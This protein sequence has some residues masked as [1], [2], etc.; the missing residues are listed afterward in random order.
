ML[1]AS[2]GVAVGLFL[3]IM[4]GV[5]ATTG[6]SELNLPE[7]IELVYPRDG[8]SILRQDAISVDLMPGYTGELEIDGV[9]VPT[10]QADTNRNAAPGD[11]VPDVLTVKFDPG[12]NKLTYQPREGAP[13]ES[14]E[15]GTH[16][17]MVIYWRIDQ[18]PERAYSY[19]WTFKVS[20]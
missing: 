20:L 1:F 14:F 7:E 5:T 13:I 9:R 10:E 17:L 16:E 11:T 18:G 19:R 3:I 8:D 4:A 6:R 12:T 15:V 2:F